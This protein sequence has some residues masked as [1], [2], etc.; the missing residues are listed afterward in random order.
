MDFERS[1]KCL[2]GFNGGG[3]EMQ[4]KANESVLRRP[5]DPHWAWI[6]SAIAATSLLFGA[7]GVTVSSTT[8]KTR[9][10]LAVGEEE[11]MA[12]VNSGGGL[13]RILQGR[14]TWA[15]H[16]IALL[17]KDW[18]NSHQD[19]D[20]PKQPFFGEHNQ[21]HIL[22]MGDSTYK[23]KYKKH[24]SVNKLWAESTGYQYQFK[25]FGKE[26]EHSCAYTQKVK[27]IRDFVCDEIPLNDWMIFVDLDAYFRAPDKA[28]LEKVLWKQQHLYN[29]HQTRA[30]GQH[31]HQCEVIA[32][33]SNKPINTGVLTMRATEQTRQLVE[34]WYQLQLHL[35]FCWG[36]ADQL[37]FQEVELEHY[38]IEDYTQEDCL[39]FEHKHYL[40]KRNTCSM[41]KLNAHKKQILDELPLRMTTPQNKHI[42][43]PIGNNSCFFDCSSL[44]TLQCHDCRDREDKEI[45][46]K[47]QPIFHHSPRFY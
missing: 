30:G 6:V 38:G 5:R 19:A 17:Q 31:A 1:T 22:Q 11:K 34:S 43:F 36:P 23:E 12:E 20:A 28:E 15:E 13:R 3:R 46:T 2:L 35:G 24:T 9:T 32:A 29:F 16:I 27:I 7:A 39:K 4:H 8:A 44:H 26:E 41:S 25:A 33:T 45:C 42:T 37:A 14:A 10:S 47:N 40:G 18:S 21:V